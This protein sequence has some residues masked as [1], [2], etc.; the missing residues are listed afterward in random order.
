[1]LRLIGDW[2]DVVSGIYFKVPGTVMEWG[3]LGAVMDE[4][5]LAMSW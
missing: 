1:M 5:G 4:T 2:S 3:E